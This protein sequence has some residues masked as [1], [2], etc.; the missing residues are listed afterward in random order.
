MEKKIK[1]LLVDDHQMVRDGL[2]E[3]INKQQGLEV[4]D[5]GTNGK[6]AIE[7]VQKSDP[8]VIIMDVDMPIM[9]GIEATEK[10]MSITTEINIIGL[11]LHDRPEVKENMLKAGASAYITKNEAFET[12]FTAFKKKQ[13]RIKNDQ[14]SKILNRYSITC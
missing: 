14:N 12:L 5:E 7:L 2:R 13:S 3:I 8:D 1:V 4:V 10:I 11:S 6:E 9:D